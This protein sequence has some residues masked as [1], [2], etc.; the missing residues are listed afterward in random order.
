MVHEPSGAEGKSTEERSQLQNKK[1]AFRR[2]AN[3]A[4]FQFWVKIQLGHVMVLED[5]VTRDL[6]KQV[7]C[8]V[9]RNGRWVEI[10][11]DQV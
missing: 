8:E 7:K 5:S 9:K 11:L 3:S 4:K 6:D 10:P 2:M 1:N